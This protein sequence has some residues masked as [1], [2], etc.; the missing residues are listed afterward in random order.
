MSYTYSYGLKKPCFDISLLY[1]IDDFLPSS[2]IFFA[3]YSVLYALSA[4]IVS[5]SGKSSTNLS[6]N[7]SSCDF[8][9]LFV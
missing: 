2:N 5:T 6:L 1:A 3:I 7:L 4:T 8:D 9:A